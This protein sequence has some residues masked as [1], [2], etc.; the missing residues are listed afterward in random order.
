MPYCGNC[1]TEYQSGQSYC[2]K[3]NN[4]L[5][6]IEQTKP[7]EVKKLSTDDIVAPRTLRIVAGIIDIMVAVALTFLLLSPRLR[8]LN[9]IGIKRI[10]SFS[11]PGLYLILK[12]C[13][14]GKSI[15]KLFLGLTVYNT[16][17]KKPTG[18]ADSIIRNWFLGIP[19]IG[20]TIMSALML[21]QIILTNKRWGDKM[22]H[23]IVIKDDIVESH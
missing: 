2:T 6:N 3:C 9:M 17:E 12:D 7:P 20:P 10:I 4:P 16:I 18:L 14:D 11:A 19:I 22:T 13:I 15:G 8:M 21:I 1:G 23:T 5:S